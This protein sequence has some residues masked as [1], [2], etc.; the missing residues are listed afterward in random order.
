MSDI[1]FELRRISTQSQF[2]RSENRPY[3]SSKRWLKEYC[4]IKLCGPRQSGHS[5]AAAELIAATEGDVWYISNSSQMCKCFEENYPRAL[6]KNGELRAFGASSI[7]S[8]TL[9]VSFP[10]LVIVDC[11]SFINKTQED[12]LYDLLSRQTIP[13]PFHMVFLE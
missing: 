2:L 1:L 4:T 3:I 6:P 10:S 13:T 5:L 12:A 9:G 7:E 11:A 8:A